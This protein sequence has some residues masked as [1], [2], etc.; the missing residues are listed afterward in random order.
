MKITVIVACYN[1]ETLLPLFL[2]HYAFADRII[3][4]LDSDTND[5]SE[6]ICKQF[7]NV[8]IVPFCFPDGMDD[9]MKMVFINEQAAK[10]KSGWIIAVDA[11]EF[12]FALPLQKKV[13][14]VLEAEQGNIIEA[15]MWQVYKHKTE[16]PLDPK[17]PAV[18]QRRHGDPDFSRG[19]NAFYIKPCVV[20]AGCG[21]QWA[22]GCHQ[23]IGECADMAVSTTKLHGTH[24]AMADVDLAIQRRIYG[25][26]LRQSKVNMEKGLS[27][28]NHTVTPEDIVA[29][30]LEHENDE[31]LF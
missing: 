28:H 21:V 26:K 2:Q 11:D 6:K 4:L 14:S 8:E 25:R 27:F 16:K 10:V 20:R 15:H 24:W 29:E 1:E 23:I 9:N 3:V 5:K 19:L 31:K 12:V 30:C 17:K 22:P 18:P 13:R 7:K